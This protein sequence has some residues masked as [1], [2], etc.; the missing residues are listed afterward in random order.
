MNGTM[1]LYIDQWGQ[2]IFARTR[3]HLKQQAG[4][5]KIFKIYVDKIAGSNAGKSV[6]CG[7]GIGHRWFTAYLPYEGGAP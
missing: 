3:A 4:P 1:M 6:H 5:G 7:Y 2:H